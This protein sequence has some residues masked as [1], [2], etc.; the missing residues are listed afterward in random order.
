MS[1]LSVNQI[2]SVKSVFEELLMQTGLE[3]SV[4][5]RQSDHKDYCS[6]TVFFADATTS[7]AKARA[8]MGEQLQKILPLT[9][10]PPGPRTGYDLL[11][12][13]RELG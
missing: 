3:A 2:S 12:H 4:Q 10:I 11:V 7:T 6:V 8:G 1:A 9:A 13:S 5:V